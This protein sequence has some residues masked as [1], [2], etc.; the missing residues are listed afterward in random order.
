MKRKFRQLR[1]KGLLPQSCEILGALARLC[2]WQPVHSAGERTWRKFCHGE[3]LHGGTRRAIVEE[4]A[5]SLIRKLELTHNAQ[6]EALA[7]ESAKQGLVGLLVAHATWWDLLLCERLQA[8][9]PVQPSAF[10]TT[11]ALRLAVVELAMRLCG[12]F[13]L[14]G[15]KLTFPADLF[16]RQVDAHRVLLPYVLREVLKA[17]GVTR[18]ALAEA[19]E[20]TKEAVDQWLES[21][22]IIPPQR[23]DDIAEVISSKTG[24][25][26]IHMGLGLRAVR[27]MS[28]VF[29]PLAE[30]IGKEELERLLLALVQL[31]AVGQATVLERTASL[32]DEARREALGL[33]IGLG[34]ESPLGASLR[35]AMLGKVPDESWKRAIATPPLKWVQFLAD[36]SAVETVSARV[37]K[38]LSEQRFSSLDEEQ[39]RLRQRMLLPRDSPSNP[40]A[41]LFALPPEQAALAYVVHLWSR[42]ASLAS[43]AR[44]AEALQGLG[45]LAEIC[46]FMVE[47]SQGKVKAMAE[48]LRWCCHSVFIVGC[49]DIGQ[50]HLKKNDPEAQLWSERALQALRVLPPFPTEA[51]LE[52]QFSLR[53]LRPLKQLQEDIDAGKTPTV[54]PQDFAFIEEW[55][56]SSNAE[57]A[58]PAASPPSC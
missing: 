45:M 20:V 40:Y 30:L 24:L 32:E 54:G 5:E 56:S 12:V 55:K 44:E 28:L 3:H 41:P 18:M 35:E 51:A 7:P 13:L 39:E 50:E 29:M 10:T 23:I 25:N 15:V 8:A 48:D 47:I 38:F 49:M 1:W 26:A 43:K 58:T 4:M 36:V 17:A 16:E 14:N 52:I 21:K 34:G 46:G 19:L 33:L 22:A 27:Q 53:L 2:D 11:V 9:L 42:F 31:M 57:E 37:R 6:G